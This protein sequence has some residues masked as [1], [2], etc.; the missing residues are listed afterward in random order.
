M[1]TS[2]VRV[3]G[4]LSARSHR[5]RKELDHYVVYEYHLVGD[6]VKWTV[7][8]R[9]KECHALYRATRGCE[10]AAWP[11]PHLTACHA[12]SRFGWP[13]PKHPRRRVRT[14]RSPAIIMERAA[15]LGA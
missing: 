8:R 14:V 4:G 15:Q 10:S 2:P 11:V 6:G 3:Q 9:F 5:R 7:Y 12:R 13:Y 1:R